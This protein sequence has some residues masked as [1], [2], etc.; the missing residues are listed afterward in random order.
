M[1]EW[2]IG[3]VIGARFEVRAL[4]GHGSF[5]E[6]LAVHDRDAGAAPDA[7]KALKLMHRDGS[8]FEREIAAA[9][10]VAGHP[11]LLVA[12]QALQ[13]GERR[14]LLLPCGRGRLLADWLQ[15]HIDEPARSRC[16]LRSLCELTAVLHRLGVAHDDLG[17]GN[18]MVVDDTHQETVELIDFGSSVCD[19]GPPAPERFRP[20]AFYGQRSQE[21]AFDTVRADDVRAL[22]VLT[23]LA[24]TRRHPFCDDWQIL[25]AGQWQG[26]DPF[27]GAARESGIEGPL[28]DLLQAALGR[29]DVRPD[30]AQL[31]AALGG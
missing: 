31:A 5:G 10:R 25:L 15:A 30:A 3:D 27:A 13:L 1:Q 6:V 7:L 24:L 23:V 29:A 2:Q 26:P 20:N 8:H 21:A 17:F 9:Q 22:A 4:L 19:G 28:A 16:V 14:A 11:R 18:V 12:E